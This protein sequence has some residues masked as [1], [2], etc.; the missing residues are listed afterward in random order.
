[1]SSDEEDQDITAGDLN[2]ILQEL[3][4]FKTYVTR[5][6][7]EV[8]ETNNKILTSHEDLKKELKLMRKEIVKQKEIITVQENRI[9]FLE[10][11][12][13]ENT[14]HIQNIP[15]ADN[16][17]VDDIVSTIT[18]KL[19]VKL[20]TSSIVKAF[21]KKGRSK[22]RPGDILVKF[23]TASTHDA[24]LAEAKKKKLSLLD[25]GFKG[26]TDKIFI[27]QELT[28]SNKLLFFEAR[29]LQKSKG[30]KFVWEKGGNIYV[31]KIEGA[32]AIK[33]TGIEHLKSI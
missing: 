20:T 10:K 9:N 11:Q 19:G 33:L 3:K 28:P 21:R 5:K 22:N 32:E 13:V 29:N 30:W 24:V 17:V 14:V 6:F 2:I 18:S 23:N 26:Q 12:S 1:M 15:V 8:K 4:S 27:N 7:A 31:R 25:I 16:E